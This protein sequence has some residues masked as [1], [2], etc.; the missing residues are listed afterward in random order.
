MSTSPKHDALLETLSDEQRLQENQRIATAEFRA[1]SAAERANATP[2]GYPRLAWIGATAC[3]AL[4]AAFAALQPGADTS[5]E[6][7]LANAQ[8]TVHQEVLRAPAGVSIERTFSYDAPVVPVS[9][10]QA[11]VNFY[12]E[13]LEF[14]S[15]APTTDTSAFL[16]RDG[17]NIVLLGQAASLDSQRLIQVAV[18]DLA[19]FGETLKRAGIAH[20]AGGSLQFQDADGNLWKITQAE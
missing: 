19:S 1:R 20:E 18:A 11:A 2:S 8:P 14:E 15:T 17:L 5:S 4:I 12:R 16:Q 10:L 3:M 7:T 13:Q 6:K 9:D